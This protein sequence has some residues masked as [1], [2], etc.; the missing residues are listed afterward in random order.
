[1]LCTKSKH[2]NCMKVKCTML[3]MKYK[4]FDTS[5]PRG[6]I[7]MWC[8]CSSYLFDCTQMTSPEGMW[9]DGRKRKQKQRTTEPNMPNYTGHFQYVTIWRRP[10]KSKW[11]NVVVYCK[12][13][14]DAIN[15]FMKQINC[16]II[17]HLSG[18]AGLIVMTCYNSVSKWEIIIVRL[19]C[20]TKVF[21]PYLINVC[22]YV[23]Y[24]F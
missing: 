6:V 20:R 9:K 21:V 14:D 22:C 10:A 19:L 24:Y 4:L 11:T 2:I 18:M 3:L 17:L 16:Q 12:P 23:F 8:S 13:A 1:M 5:T 7:L 15:G